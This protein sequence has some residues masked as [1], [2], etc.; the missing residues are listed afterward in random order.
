MTELLLFAVIAATLVASIRLHGLATFVTLGVAGAAIYSVPAV[1]NLQNSF[2]LIAFKQSELVPTPDAADQVVLLAWLAMLVGVL[3]ARL[4]GGDRRYLVPNRTDERHMASLAYATAFL[5]VAGIF[6]LQ[7]SGESV[8]F[9]LAAR[10]EQTADPV[11]TLWKWTALIGLVASSLSGSRKLL[12]FHVLI[13]FIIFLR[14]DRTLVAFAAAA[15]IVVARYKDP[16]WYALFTPIRI[17]GAGFAALVIFFGKSIYTVLKGGLS[18]QGWDPLSIPLGQQFLFHFEP[19][20]TFSHLSFAMRTKTHMAYGD[21]ISSILANLTIVPSWFGLSSNRYNEIISRSLPGIDFG[22]AGNYLAHGWVVAGTA[23]AMCFY[24]VLALVLR[25]CDV[26]FRRRHG[27]IKLFWCC[28]GAVIAFYI[29]RNGMDNILSFVR[30]LVIACVLTALV[31]LPLR[32][33]LTP[34]RS[35]R[36]HPSATEA[37]LRASPGELEPRTTEL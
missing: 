19:L 37:L 3:V 23:G 14:G 10:A 21:F 34:A 9:F 20:T 28:V 12:L 36:A 13:L 33:L 8:Y 27:A 24:L 31:A 25:L 35:R 6:Y 18:G 4:F 15:L 2:Y 22:V 30:Q 29:H 16:R 26:Q 5:G 11:S 32:A 7:L 17:V 1:V